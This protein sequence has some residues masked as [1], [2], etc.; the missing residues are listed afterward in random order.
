MYAKEINSTLS[1]EA[2]MNSLSQFIGTSRYYKYYLN[3]VLT[4]GTRYLAE[5]LRCFWLL[6]D[7][8]IFS[9][10][11]QG[12]DLLVCQYDDDKKLL[13]ISDNEQI[14]AKNSYD[15]TSFS[16]VPTSP[17]EIYFCHNVLYLPSE[18]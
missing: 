15:Y 2:F 14:I 4:D 9:K 18:H 16:I 1:F 6:D 13:T 10:S 5:Q 17:I 8:A 11:Y 3:T 7:I 12:H